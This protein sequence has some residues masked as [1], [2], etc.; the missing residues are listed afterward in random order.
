MNP[1]Y[2][3]IALAAITLAACGHPFADRG[4]N[5]PLAAEPAPAVAA[6]QAGDGTLVL[7]ANATLQALL[8]QHAAPHSGNTGLYVPTGAPPRLSVTESWVQAQ[9]PAL[10]ALMERS[11]VA[12]RA[13]PAPPAEPG[14]Q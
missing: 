10:R 1:R 14:Q 8:Q 12:A 7:H 6:A 11:R 13:L 2:L 9:A 4:I 5:H 3:A